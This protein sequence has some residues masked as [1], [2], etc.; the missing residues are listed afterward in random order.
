MATN[1]AALPM[2]PTLGENEYSGTRTD[3]RVITAALTTISLMV[4]LTAMVSVPRT[5]CCSPRNSAGE[6][7]NREY[8]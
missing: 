5:N 3:I 7:G 8:L 1:A 4:T 6:M 2:R